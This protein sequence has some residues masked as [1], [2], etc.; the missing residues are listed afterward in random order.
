LEKMHNEEHQNLC[1]SPNIII[2]IKSRRTR[3][4]G[5]VEEW[6]EEE[7]MQVFVGKPEGKRPL[8]RL[9]RSWE[10]SIEIDLREIK[11]VGMS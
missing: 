1:S 7:C 4:V 6:R 5:H 3:W 2:M 8:G 9:N 11:W 10:Y